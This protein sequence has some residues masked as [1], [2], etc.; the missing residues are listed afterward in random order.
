[1]NNTMI[2]WLH[3]NMLFIVVL[4]YV[5]VRWPFRLYALFI[6]LMPNGSIYELAY[7]S[8]TCFALESYGIL[9]MTI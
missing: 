5:L 8:S 2:N 3:I 7:P 6:H 4:G 1:M 9:Q